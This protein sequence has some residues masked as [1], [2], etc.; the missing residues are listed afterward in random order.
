VRRSSARI[1]AVDHVTSVGAGGD[2][3]DREVATFTQGAANGETV[4]P[5]EHEIEEH[6]VDGRGVQ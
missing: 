1:R 5:R 4:D 3:D 6:D 2:H